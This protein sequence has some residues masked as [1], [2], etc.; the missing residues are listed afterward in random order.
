M[1]NTPVLLLKLDK[2][3]T[4][5]GTTFSGA[6]I[7]SRLTISRALFITSGSSE[8]I[9][10]VSGKLKEASFLIAILHKVFLSFSSGT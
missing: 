6:L 4:E 5:L 3:F 9:V 1:Q 7:G 2:T 8:W 10:K